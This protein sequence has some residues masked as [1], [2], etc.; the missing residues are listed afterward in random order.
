[1][2]HIQKKVFRSSLVVQWIRICLPTQGTQVRS[3]VGEDVTCLGELSLCN[4]ATTTE[5]VLHSLCSA[6]RETTA[7]RSLFTATTKE[8]PLTIT[9]ESLCTAV[10]PNLNKFK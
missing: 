4:I 10:Q 7:M 2:V 1:M 8:S 6:T 9:R 3:L 5:P